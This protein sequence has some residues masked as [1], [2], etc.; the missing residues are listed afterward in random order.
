M[1]NLPP[2]KFEAAKVEVCFWNHVVTAVQV[3]NEKGNDI[4]KPTIPYCA[5]LGVAFVS[6][7]HLEIYSCFCLSVF[8]VFT[9]IV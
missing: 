8:D 3:D 4:I 6:I 2:K 7:N 1:Q 9:F 5:F